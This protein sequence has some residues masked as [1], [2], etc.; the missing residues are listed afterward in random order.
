[1]DYEKFQCFGQMPVT[2]DVLILPSEL[3]YFI[4]VEAAQLYCMRTTFLCQPEFRIYM[5]SSHGSLLN[6]GSGLNKCEMSSEGCDWLRVCQPWTT[7]QRS[8]G[9]NL[10]QAA[11]PAP[12]LR[13]RG[14]GQS[15]FG[16]SSGENLIK[17]FQ[18]LIS[19][20]K[21]F[22]GESPYFFNIQL[23]IQ[24]RITFIGF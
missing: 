16:R 10:Q 21:M 13:G 9:R 3:R 7:D 6:A 4:K 2:P 20:G 19:T 24:R 17:N 14:E 11:D 15:L 18:K 8:R 23:F 12:L 5:Y 22:N 1:M